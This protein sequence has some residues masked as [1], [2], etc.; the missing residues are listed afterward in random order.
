MGFIM[1]TDVQF[2]IYRSAIN[3]ILYCVFLFSVTGIMLEMTIGILHQ[4]DLNKQ[5]KGPIK[6]F[7]SRYYRH[8][9]AQTRNIMN[10]QEGCTK[11]D[12]Y[13][14]YTL[15]PGSCIFK[16]EEFD[17]KLYINSLGL[18]DD[19]KSIENPN[20]IF[21]GDSHTMGWGV[22]QEEVFPQ[23]FEKITGLRTLNGGVTSYGTIRELMLLEKIDLQEVKYVFIQYSP[24]DWRENKK[25]FEEGVL[26][27]ASQNKFNTRIQKYENDK[28]YYLGMYS[29]I[30]LKLVWQKFNS[31]LKILNHK[32]NAFLA[33]SNEA[34]HVL[35]ALKKKSIDSLGPKFIIFSIGVYNKN[36]P[37]FIN[38]LSA[39]L[40]ES[41]LDKVISTVDISN[42]FN[43]ED[44]FTLDAHINVKGHQKVA[45]F[46]S[47]IYFQ[48]NNQS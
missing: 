12:D 9:Y 43:D 7:Y 48:K 36:D 22:E 32:D 42:I 19:E 2:S 44:Y 17:T 21:L 4:L 27:I 33:Q 47:S 31:K 35:N 28:K 24:N 3:T 8:V 15:R 45:E 20:I 13:L 23:I 11:Y 34:K 14:Y 29:N 38:E 46:L 6:Y 1:K 40:K 30:F 25:F 37:K 10:Y 16:N 26:K 41:S 39:L 18:R 5:L